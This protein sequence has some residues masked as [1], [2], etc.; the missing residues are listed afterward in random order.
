M[1]F[2]CAQQ[3]LNAR[4]AIVL[5]AVPAKTTMSILQYIYIDAGEEGI[6]FFANDMEN[7]IET[8][9]NGTVEETG[10]V[11]IEAALFSSIVRTLPDSEVSVSVDENYLV[12]LDCEA[13]HF[14][15]PGRSGDDFT[16]PPEVDKSEAV[17]LRQATLKSFIAQTVFSVSTNDANRIM[18]G[19]LLKIEEDECSMTALDGH[20]IA[21][22]KTA[23]QAPVESP[24]KAIISGKTL[25]KLRDILSD[26]AEKEV[27]IY[28]TQKLACFSVSDTLFT[29]RLI[30]GEYFDVSQ[31]ISGDYETKLQ[32]GRRQF[33]EGIERAMTLSHDGDKKPIILGIQD[34]EMEIKVSS[35]RGSMNSQVMV[36][37]DGKDILIGFNPKFL[38]DALRVI[39]DDN[40][41]IYFV[42]PKA[43][44]YIRNEENTYLYMILP[45]NFKTVE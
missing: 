21:M 4:T 40:L 44:C 7:G 3:E 25:L 8:R 32:V 18:T 43:P 10:Y 29:T 16:F 17:T 1:K 34:Q 26:Q 14:T 31:M 39:E 11:A 30:D 20:R 6:R 12:T 35:T 19:A 36:T 23:L 24:K 22:R 37:K 9:V 5:K 15:L 42:N 2:I 38:T 41:T 13:T 33:L 27:D 45:I 28:F